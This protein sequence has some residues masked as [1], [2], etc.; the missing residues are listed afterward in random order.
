MSETELLTEIEKNVGQ[1]E[2]QVKSKLEEIKHFLALN[3]AERLK[4]AEE[5]LRAY[6]GSRR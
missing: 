4:M 1:T 2:E 3:I 5:A 6:D